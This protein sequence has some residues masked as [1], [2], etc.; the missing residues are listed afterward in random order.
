MALRRTPLAAALI[1]AF[2]TPY[3]LA[4]AAEPPAPAA[5]AAPI[6][7]LAASAVRALPEVTVTGRKG[8]DYAPLRSRRSAAKLPTALRDIP[9]SVTVI[10]SAPCEAQGASVAVA[11]AL[12]N[13]PGITIGAAEGG[14]IG[15]NFN[16]RGFSA[17]TDLYLDGMR[18]RGQYYRDMFSLDAV[19]VL[20]GPSSM[21]FGR[22]STGGIINQ[23]SKQPTLGTVLHDVAVSVG[24]SDCYRLTADFNAPLSDT[25]A[26][27]VASMGRT[28]ARRA[29]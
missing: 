14:Q 23:V 18:D 29:M 1:A 8:D 27:R 11:D 25:A 9:Q 19:E 16:L 6:D 7:P 22:G 12:R 21:L 2:S 15:N 20:K 28:S 17:R 3:P 24:T 26:L 5:E 13:V 4:S 10:N